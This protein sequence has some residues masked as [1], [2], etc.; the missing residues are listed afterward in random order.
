MSY[1]ID[2]Y[3]GNVRAQKNLATMGTFVSLFPQLVAGPIVRYSDIA[4]ELEHR[5]HHLQNVADGIR[6]FVY[7]LGKKVLIANAMG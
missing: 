3:R 7:G 6:R 5:E 4:E 2:V 1:T